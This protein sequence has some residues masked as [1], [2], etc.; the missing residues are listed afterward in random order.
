MYPKGIRREMKKRLL[1]LRHS[2][3]LLVRQPQQMGNNSERFKGWCKQ[4]LHCGLCPWI[5]WEMGEGK[6]IYSLASKLGKRG[7]MERKKLGCFGH[8]SWVWCLRPLGHPDTR[9]F[10]IFR[11]LPTLTIKWSHRWSQWLL[12]AVTLNESW[13]FP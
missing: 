6:G 8:I 7:G 3:S 2:Q 11:L 5:V 9:H 12:L 1:F 10:L 13:P 4:M